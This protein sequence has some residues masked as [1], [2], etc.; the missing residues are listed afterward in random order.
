MAINRTKTRLIGILFIT[1]FFF[2]GG[3][4]ALLDSVLTSSNTAHFLASLPANTFTFII[5]A[6]LMLM[7]SFNVAALG[8]LL[9]P[10][11]QER[12][13]TLGYGY[14]AGRVAEAVLL[15]IGVVALLCL[16]YLADGYSIHAASGVKMYETLASLLQNINYWCFQTAMLAL[17]IGSFGFC[18]VLWKSRLVPATLAIM[19]LAGY[20]L[21]FI[22]AVL[23]LFGYKIGMM[24][25]VPGGLCEIGFGIWV[26][27]KGFNASKA[28]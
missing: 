26:W 5:G 10:I 7:N 18:V 27:A 23:E 24:L 14:F 15:A 13:T 2:Y 12:S 6:M 22:S 1:P 28:V 3:G 16:V 11:I 25:S 17:C 21:L 4:N 8:V 9:L 19:M 20:V